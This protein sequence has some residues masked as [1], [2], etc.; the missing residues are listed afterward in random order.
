MKIKKKQTKL[1]SLNWASK[2]LVGA[3][4][5]S[6]TASWSFEYQDF[7]KKVKNPY[8]VR[9]L[10]EK[11]PRKDIEENLR[12]F[13]SAG[14]P[15][16]LIGSAG[17][18]KAQDY[19]EGK[20]K[21]ASS[22]NA[23]YKRQEFALSD[24]SVSKEKGVN[25]IWE[26][27]GATKPEEVIILTANYD[28]LLKDPKTG[29][30]ILKGE[31]PGADNNGT[32]VS[33]LLS[34]ME[35]FNKLDIP[36]TVVLVFLDAEEFGAQGS[37]EFVKSLNSEMKPIGFINLTMLGHDSRTTDTEKKMNN[38]K[39]Y[40]SGTEGDSTFGK[41]IT[42]LGEREYGTISFKEEKI[43]DGTSTL[44]FP[45]TAENLWGAGFVGITL[46]QN[47]QTDL[48]PRYMTANDFAETLNIATYTNVFKYVTYAV[49]SWNYDIVK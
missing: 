43:N 17:H 13:L 11:M 30:V 21:A 39:L 7:E 5:F 18:K 16:R 8:Q 1:M 40:T 46:T 15:S 35:I 3:L 22:T 27:K 28:T 25:F 31:M 29:K 2:L 34:M 24:E 36:K 10:V 20:L 37:K 19:L 32:G 23:S 26:K 45:A 4:V 42:K 47:R 33:I 48:N 49:L 41:L 14:R 12:A 44:G 38:L 6:S 9:S